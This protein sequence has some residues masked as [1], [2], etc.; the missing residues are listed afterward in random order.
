MGQSSDEAAAGDNEATEPVYVT[1]SG[2]FAGWL[3]VPG[4]P[5]YFTGYYR[6]FEGNRATQ[7]SEG[8][9]QRRVHHRVPR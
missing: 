3:D 5:E 1:W 7:I 4:E 8:L 2:D 9:D 6:M